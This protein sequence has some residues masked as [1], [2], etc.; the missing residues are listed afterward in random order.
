MISRRETE[1]AICQSFRFKLPVRQMT[2]ICVYF[3]CASLRPLIFFRHATCVRG[4][5][6]LLWR[7]R[8]PWSSREHRRSIWFQ[9][10]SYHPFHSSSPFI[11]EDRPRYP[12]TATP[13]QPGRHTVRG[14]TSAPAATRRCVSVLTDIFSV[15]LSIRLLGNLI[16]ALVLISGDLHSRISPVTVRFI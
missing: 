16:F 9:Q 13:G 14:Q 11:T 10:M 12:Q 5:P 8:T 2:L 1:R 6:Q 4:I 15:A 3:V 7:W